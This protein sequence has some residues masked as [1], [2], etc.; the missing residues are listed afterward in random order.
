M[1]KLRGNCY[2]TSEALYHLLGGKKAG[3]TPQR[4][5]YMGDT[6]WFLLHEETQTVLDPTANQFQYPPNHND[7]MNAVG[8][9]FLTKNPSKR[10]KAL[11]QTLLWQGD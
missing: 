4:M 7:Y 8:S 11:M 10:A 5:H 2:V 1:R 6:H 9:G 3:W